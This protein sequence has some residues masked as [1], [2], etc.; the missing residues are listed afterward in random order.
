M[1]VAVLSDRNPLVVSRQLLTTF[2]NDIGRLPPDVLKAR[3]PR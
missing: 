3:T 2:A 1:R